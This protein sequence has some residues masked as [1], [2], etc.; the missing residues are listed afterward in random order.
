MRKVIGMDLGD[1]RHRVVVFDEEGEEVERA[2]VGNT[3]RQVQR[4]FARHRG[5]AVAMEAG[6]SSPWV[7]RLL[8]K[9]GHEVV[10][11][12]PR[13]LRAIWDADDKSD[14]RDARILGLIFRMEPR[15][16]HP[17]FHRSEEA[18][19]DLELIKARNQL[20][21]CRSKLV[22]HVRCVVKGTGARLPGGSAASF[23]HRACSHIPESLK[24]SLAGTTHTG[25]Q[26]QRR[27][28]RHVG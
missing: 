1:K 24:P 22:N 25:L 6:T 9:M 26:S 11:G 2:W 23:A 10:V 8:T 21:D 14:E 13:K 18:Q 5:A 27:E 3:S 20:V 17:I 12:N 19:M 28:H 4:Y 7:S 16:L 15:L